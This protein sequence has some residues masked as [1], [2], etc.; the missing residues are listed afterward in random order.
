MKNRRSALTLRTMDHAPDATFDQTYAID[1]AVGDALYAV[2][3]LAKDM[4][5]LAEFLASDDASEVIY[6]LNRL[7]GSSSYDQHVAEA[8]LAAT[9]A[10]VLAS[11]TRGIYR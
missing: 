7:T 10:T 9:R 5:S 8:R 11:A 2:T 4:T 6:A 1:R 3:R